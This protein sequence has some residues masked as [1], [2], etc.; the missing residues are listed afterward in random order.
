MAFYQ[1]DEALNTRKHKYKRGSFRFGVF[2]L[3]ANQGFLGVINKEESPSTSV[4]PPLRASRAYVCACA[5]IRRRIQ[6]RHRCSLPYQNHVWSLALHFHS[7]YDFLSFTSHD[8][9]LALSYKSYQ[10][11]RRRS[12]NIVSRIPRYP[13]QFTARPGISAN[14]HY[15]VILPSP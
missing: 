14:R 2:V 4:K 6:N 9:E 15:P 11:S 8:A 10:P 13:P 7:T 12:N 1:L 5:W 3:L